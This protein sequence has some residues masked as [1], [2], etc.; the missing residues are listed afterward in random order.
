MWG[1]EKESRETYVL[2]PALQV[3]NTIQLA[4]GRCPPPPGVGSQRDLGHSPKNLARGSDGRH[5]PC[6]KQVFNAGLG[7]VFGQLL[8]HLCQD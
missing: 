5:E 1:L 3:V 8:S 4:L 7:R 6:L 2:F